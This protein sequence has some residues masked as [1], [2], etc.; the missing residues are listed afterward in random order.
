MKDPSEKHWF[1]LYT[2]PRHEF[3]A[4]LQLKS[5]SVDNY[6]PTYFVTKKWSDRKKKINEPVFRGYIF[7][8]A[9]EKERHLSLSQSAIVRCISF[10]GKPSIVPEWQINNLKK[11][12]SESHDILISNKIE[13]GFSIKI[14]DGP[15]KD[16]IG[17][18]TETQE[19]KWLAVSVDL[20]HRSIIVRLPKESGIQVHPLSN[21]S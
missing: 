21:N 15:F 6:L 9:S 10:S 11:I 7:I 3:K 5:V 18:V 12:L 17:V 20:I 1:A 8:H 13:V 19:D 4:E 14:T 2:K 16:V